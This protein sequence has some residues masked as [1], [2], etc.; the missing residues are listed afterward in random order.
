MVPE[1]TRDKLDFE[2]NSK[3]EP[4]WNW[5][6][7]VP[8]FFTK[9]L[10]ISLYW[11]EAIE[12]TGCNF[13]SLSKR[14]EACSKVGNNRSISCNR[15]PGKIANRGSFLWLSRKGLIRSIIGW[16]TYVTAAPLAW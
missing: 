5:Y 14:N 3:L 6:C 10:T 8:Y 15:D 9:D 4:S 1:L 11:G 16:P 13:N 2:I 7:F 12:I